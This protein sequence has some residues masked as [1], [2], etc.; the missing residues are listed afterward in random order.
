MGEGSQWIGG[1]DISEATRCRLAQL[2]Q[3]SISPAAQQ[4]LRELS[5]QMTAS[6]RAEAETIASGWI[7]GPTPLTRQAMS[8]LE[9]A[10]TLARSSRQAKKTAAAA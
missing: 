6:E 8:G 5:G 3:G 4:A 2:A 10:E 1:A 9:R 7:T